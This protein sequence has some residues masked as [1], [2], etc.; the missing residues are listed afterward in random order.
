MRSGG[1]GGAVGT[2]VRVSPGGIRRLTP[3]GPPLQ[4]VFTSQHCTPCCAIFSPRSDAYTLGLSGRNRAPKQ[5]EKVAF[6]SVKA[7][8]GPATLAV[9][10]GRE[11][12]IARAGDRR[13]RGGQ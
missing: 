2:C 3:Y 12:D 11:W 13:A 10:P 9:E 7:R 1:P 6:G 8:P 5:A 4:P